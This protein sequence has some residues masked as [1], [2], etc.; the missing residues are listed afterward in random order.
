MDH[1]RLIQRT[2]A[3][4]PERSLPEVC[5]IMGIGLAIGFA[6]FALFDTPIALPFIALLGGLWGYL[7][8]TFITRV[9]ALIEGRFLDV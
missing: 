4:A 8:G 2:L 1:L 5:L 7:V 3:E 6:F 9:K